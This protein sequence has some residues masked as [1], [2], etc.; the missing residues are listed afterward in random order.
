MLPV[1]FGAHSFF[2][3]PYKCRQEGC[4]KR[5]TD[6]SSLRKHVKSVHVAATSQSGA[7]DSKTGVSHQQ[8]YRLDALEDEHEHV[9]L[10]RKIWER[11]KSAPRQKLKKQKGAK[12]H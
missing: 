3:K 4:E 6:P 9:E 12:C 8:G 11:N 10:L 7:S 1:N 2:Q 5:Y